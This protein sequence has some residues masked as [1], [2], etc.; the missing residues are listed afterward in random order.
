LC[1]V[2]CGH[3]LFHEP[4]GHRLCHEPVWAP[5]VPCAVDIICAMNRV[6]TV[7][8][9]SRVGT[10]CA[11]SR[12]EVCKVCCTLCAVIQTCCGSLVWRWTDVAES[13]N[14]ERNNAE[15]WSIFSPHDNQLVYP[16][17]WQLKFRPA[18]SKKEKANPSQDNLHR[19]FVL[20]NLLMLKRNS[21]LQGNVNEYCLYC[22]AHTKHN[23]E[24]S[25]LMSGCFRGNRN[26]YKC[27][28]INWLLLRWGIVRAQDLTVVHIVV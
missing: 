10:I 23:H 4:C 18:T 3:N 12:V 28:P 17:A 25:H 11:M 2:L 9:M 27:E 21:F 26:D 8:A 13:R 16:R 1:H 6:D 5:F 14:V 15:Q 22:A 24:N 20:S 19:I 7:C